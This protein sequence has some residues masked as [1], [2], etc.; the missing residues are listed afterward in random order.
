MKNFKKFINEM[1][2]QTPFG[3]END[4]KK[5]LVVLVGPPA[6]GKSTWIASKFPKGSVIVVNRD[7]IVEEVARNNGWTYDD[8]FLAPPNLNPDPAMEAKFG[9]AIPNRGYTPFAYEKIV[10][11]NK[12]V[13]QILANHFEQAVSSGKN[14]VVDMTNMTAGVRRNVLV[15]VPKGEYFKRAVVFTM[16]ESDLPTLFDRMQRRSDE[17][18]AK[19][20]SKT[21][22]KDVVMRMAKSFQQVSPEEGF[23]KVDTVDSF[24][25]K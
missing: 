22:G 19:G 9:K 3:T 13:N 20:G 8:M 2:T 12:E 21:V 16:K 17:I 15:K 1:I 5:E 6:V 4:G 11:A 18:K 7:N 14:I 25:P 24:M 23:D 10:E